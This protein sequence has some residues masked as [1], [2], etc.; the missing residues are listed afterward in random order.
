MEADERLPVGPRG[1][2][3]ERGERG[4]SRLQG[5][6]VVVLFVLAVLPG[7]FGWFWWVH[8][9]S[10]VRSAVLASCAFAADVG[11]APIVVAPG[12]KAPELGVSIVADSRAQWRRLG[13]PGRLA[14]PQPSFAKWARYY[15][16]DER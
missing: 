12:G 9:V 8:E 2:K 15:H 16:L 14:P 11:S 13:C 1:A 3:G 10:Q 7:A 5:R 6:A 4:L